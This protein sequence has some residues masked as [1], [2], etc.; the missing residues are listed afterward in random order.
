MFESPKT[1]KYFLISAIVCNFVARGA[2]SMPSPGLLFM[3][4][5]ENKRVAVYAGS[6][7]P[8][9]RG[10][11]SVIARAA[12]I[13]DR[14]VVAVGCNASKA[15][16]AE[17]LPERCEA[18][19]SALAKLA[20]ELARRCEVVAYCG[21]LTVDLAESVGARW[22]VRGARSGSEFDAEAALAD[23]NRRLSGIE[24]VIIP[25]LPE[26]ASCSS[27]VVRELESYGRDA[28]QFLP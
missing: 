24:T 16:A 26:L 14:L 12:A 3:E 25:A 17:A 18:V 1:T 8:V 6:F 22:L 28:S 4:S 19:E 7:N 5:S 15:S 9:T 27:S 10:H 20:P 13:F 23:I 11:L 21:R 2:V